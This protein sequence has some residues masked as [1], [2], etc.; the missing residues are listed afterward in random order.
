[1]NRPLP[2]FREFAHEPGGVADLHP[3]GPGVRGVPSANVH[4]HVPRG[5]ET[6]SV[7]VGQQ[8]RAL[9]ADH[10][11]QATR[12][13]ADTQALRGQ[14]AVVQ[15]ADFLQAQEPTRLDLQHP[16]PD[17][18]HVRTDQAGAG[19]LR[20][21]AAHGNDVPGGVHPHAVGVRPGGLHDPAYHVLLAAAGASG[22]HQGPEVLENQGKGF[23]GGLCHGNLLGIQRSK[24]LRGRCALTVKCG[25]S[26]S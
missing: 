9:R 24:M 23:T 10:A 26:T 12:G 8:V 3:H 15:P 4:V 14:D 2:Q 22:G 6:H 7:R 25:A 16:E 17:L 13:G 1:M 5:R 19:A 20:G 18:V 21:G 11:A